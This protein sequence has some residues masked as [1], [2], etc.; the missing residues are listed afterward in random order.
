MDALGEA[1][2]RYGSDRVRVSITPGS[3]ESL[4]LGRE[5]NPYPKVLAETKICVAP[6]GTT[7]ETTR[8]YEALKAGCVVI[9]DKLPR[10]PFYE[11]SPILQIEDWRDLPDMIVDLMRDPARLQDLHER[12]LR[13]W[14]DVV[15]EAALARRYAGALGLKE[16]VGAGADGRPAAPAFPVRSAVLQGDVLA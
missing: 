2:R 8:P 3:Q 14:R 11:D 13:Y 6:R 4:S 1:E 7:H 10:H 5:E 15:S 16:R 9:T 12:G